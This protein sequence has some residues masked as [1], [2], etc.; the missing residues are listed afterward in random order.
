MRIKGNVTLQNR[1]LRGLQARLDGFRDRG[2]R[3]MMGAAALV[4]CA[5]SPLQAGVTLVL[6]TDGLTV[7]DA[8]NNIT[9]LAD[10]NLAASSRFGLP[11]CSGSSGLSSRPLSWCAAC[12]HGRPTLARAWSKAPR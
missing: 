4:A 7:Y 3:T 8:T 10:F 11:V 5:L 6:S 9:W 2:I 12:R 1:G